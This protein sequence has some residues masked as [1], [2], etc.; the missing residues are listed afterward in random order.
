MQHNDA[1][2]VDPWY[3]MD[4]I[5]PLHSPSSSSLC[6]ISIQTWDQLGLHS[7]IQLVDYAR[8]RHELVRQLHVSW[9]SLL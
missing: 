1:S 8:A 4:I 2:S 3:E 7:P 9:A 5:P 6:P